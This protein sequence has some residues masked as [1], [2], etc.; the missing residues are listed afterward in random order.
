MLFGQW[1]RR[2]HGSGGADA[3]DAALH[4]PYVQP[5]EM[6]G[7]TMTGFITLAASERLAG[8]E[9]TVVCFVGDTDP[10]LVWA[11]VLPAYAWRA[12]LVTRGATRK[13]KR[14]E[15]LT[16]FVSRRFAN[17][18]SASLVNVLLARRETS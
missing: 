15:L 5:I 6:A 7:R 2:P 3:Y 18:R 17:M 11:L 14:G 8:F 13:T 4:E 16:E 12:W 9:T 1:T 10:L